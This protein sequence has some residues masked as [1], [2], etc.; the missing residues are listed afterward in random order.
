MLAHTIHLI[1]KIDPLKHLLGKAT[2]I[3][4]LDKWMMILSEFDIEYIERKE[5]KGKVIV[6][7]LANFLVQDDATIQVNFPN[8]HLMY[9][10]KRTW[11]M[12]FDGS[13]MKSCSGVC[14]LFVSPHG[15]LI[16]KSYKLLFPC[17]NNI[18]KYE[19]LTNGLNM[20]IEWRIMELHI[21]GDS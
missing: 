12:L 20:A 17:T 14:L 4:R 2:L 16:P 10:T 13:F 19:A 15:Y 7:Q 9:M 3:G 11:K 8:E 21:Y 18:V 1:E 6:D 5:I